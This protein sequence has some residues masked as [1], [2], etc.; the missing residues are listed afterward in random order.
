MLD[1]LHMELLALLP[2]DLATA[3]QNNLSPYSRR[4]LSSQHSSHSLVTSIF[5]GMLQSEVRQTIEI[6]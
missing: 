4:R 2:S 3:M 1:R 6:S 5:G